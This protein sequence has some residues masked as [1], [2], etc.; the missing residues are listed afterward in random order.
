MTA[1]CDD[2][3]ENYGEELKAPDWLE[4]DVERIAEILPPLETN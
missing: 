3:Q 2:P 1:F 4:V